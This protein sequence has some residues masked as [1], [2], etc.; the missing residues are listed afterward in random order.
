[1][2]ATRA[3]GWGKFANFCKI[4]KMRIGFMERNLFYL[5][6]IA[7]SIKNYFYI[8][9]ASSGVGREVEL[10]FGS[11]LPSPL[12]CPL[13]EEVAPSSLSSP[14]DG[15]ILSCLQGRPKT[16]IRP[17]M[18]SSCAVVGIG[19]VDVLQWFSHSVRLPNRLEFPKQPDHRKK[20][21]VFVSTS[22]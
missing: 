20:L 6:C 21:Q 16:D 7:I 19:F 2:T 17:P 18:P 8:P 15:A 4:N 10:E 14:M 13:P 22:K 5:G 3:L 9:S 12:F 11:G 1:M